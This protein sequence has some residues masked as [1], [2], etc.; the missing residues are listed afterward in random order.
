VDQRQIV[1]IHSR[2]RHGG[3]QFLTKI[4]Y[5]FFELKEHDTKTLLFPIYFE[6]VDF[7]RFVD[8]FVNYTTTHYI[9]TLL[10]HTMPSN[11]E[12]FLASMQYSGN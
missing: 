8:H 1:L 9:H 2:E 10:L 12:T 4:S 3:F 11:R 5:L 7:Y 6:C